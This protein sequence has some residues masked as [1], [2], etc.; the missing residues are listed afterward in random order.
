MLYRDLQ[1]IHSSHRLL[2]TGTPLQNQLA[3]LWSLL[4]F[5]LPQV[6]EDISQLSDWFN[7]PF[8]EGEDDE[9]Q[10]DIAEN[11]IE[12]ERKVEAIDPGDK[13]CESDSI[14]RKDDAEEDV[15]DRGKF[16][17][18]EMSLLHELLDGRDQVSDTIDKDN[19]TKIESTRGRMKELKSL[20]SKMIGIKSKRKYTKRSIDSRNMISNTNKMSSQERQVIITSLHRILKPFI[21]RRLKSHVLIDM[22][23]K[24][25]RIVYCPMFPIQYAAQ[26]LIRQ[27]IQENE[28]RLYDPGYMNQ[29]SRHE[30]I[31]RLCNPIHKLTFNNIMIQL[32]KLCNHPYLI[33]EDM[34]SIPDELYYKYLIYSSGKFFML[35]KLMQNLLYEEDIAD[36]QGIPL[37]PTMSAESKGSS[38]EIEINNQSSDPINRSSMGYK[39]K[40]L[41]FSQFTT[42]LDILQG[43]F[44]TYHNIQA[45]RLDGNIAR[46]DRLEEIDRFQSDDPKI[47][48]PVFLL[49]TRAGTVRLGAIQCDSA[50]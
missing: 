45:A 38:D 10:T 22:I 35:H 6:F 2:L 21:L 13:L 46:E 12:D 4:G 17:E 32:R 26:N 34:Q 16:R 31:N 27:F 39:H 42:M 15:S 23:P 30:A 47:S 11:L 7:Q 1:G 44:L 25:E 29:S 48:C 20:S 40:I 37:K 43:Y 49:S 50:R 33:L 9:L 36:N 18:N 14:E 5:V 41:I 24:I 8:N 28:D 3:E 19:T